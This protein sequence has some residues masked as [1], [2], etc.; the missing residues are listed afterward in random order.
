MQST[1][2][3]MTEAQLE[4]VFE[5]SCRMGGAQ[6]LSFP[7]VVAGGERALSLHYIK[8]DQILKYIHMYVVNYHVIPVFLQEWRTGSNGRWL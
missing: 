4:S 8:N 7:P 6:W 2:P 1:T 5:H 3:D